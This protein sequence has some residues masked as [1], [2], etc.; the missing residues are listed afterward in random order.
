M[1]LSRVYTK[2]SKG[3]L[4]GSLKTRALGRSHA[5]LLALIDGKSTVSDLL[6]AAGTRLSENRLAAILDEL[7]SAGLIRLLTAT[8]P[9][10]DDLGF[11]STIIVSEANTQAFFDA[12]ADV[13]NEKLRRAEIQKAL[14]ESNAALLKEVTA[15]IAA[16][17]KA[18]D[19]QKAERRAPFIPEKDQQTRLAREAAAAQAAIKHAQAA[20]QA[21]TEAETRAKALEAEV[22]ARTEKAYQAEQE[23][24]KHAQSEAE[25][26]A[27]MLE[28][29][30]AR[31]QAEKKAQQ[32]VRA[33]EA[34]TLKARADAE[35]K[36]RLA[37]ATAALAQRE[38]QAKI[39]SEEEAQRSAEMKSRLQETEQAKIQALAEVQTLSQ[40]L[41]E[42][43]IAAELETRVKRRL[44]ARAREEADTHARLQAEAQ[45][46]L[47]AEA[48]LRAEAEAKARMEAEAKA[49]IAAEAA[50]KL[51]A[52]RK[53]RIE[54]EHKARLEA[55][56]RVKAETEA[57]K[58]A[59][60]KQAAAKAKAHAEEEARREAAAEAKRQA[61]AAIEAKRKAERKARATEEAQR[62]AA[63]AEKKQAEAKL[64]AERKARHEAEQKAA[65]AKR[66]A[67]A[68][69][70]IE[71]ERRAQIEEE[72]A[73]QEAEA[74]AKS[75]AEHKARQE[76]EQRA[77]E[78]KREAEAK[79]KIEA[80]RKAKIEEEKVRIEAEA[81]AKSEAEREKQR[82]AAAEAKHQAEVKAKIEAE[83]KAK[84]EEEKARQETEARAKSE[85]EQARREAEAAAQLKL[86][87]EQKAHE[88][89][90]QKA[91]AAADAAARAQA[92]A[93]AQQQAQ[94][95]ARRQAEEQ[96]RAIAAAEAA[97]RREAEAVK[98]QMELDQ[99]AEEARRA[100]ESAERALETERQARAVAESAAKNLVDER[101]KMESAA[102]SR[103]QERLRAAEMAS[104][105]AR[106]EMEEA[107]RRAQAEKKREEYEAARMR[108]EAEARAVAAARAAPLPVLAR[109]TRKPLVFDRRFY[110]RSALT[111]FALLGAAIGVAHVVPF[112]FYIPQVESALVQSLGQPVAI[113]ALH[114]SMYPM[115]HLALDAVV[116]GD[117]APTR[118]E[119]ANLYPAWRSLFDDVKVMRRVELAAV[120]F[121]QDSFDALPVWGRA[122]ARAVPLQFERVQIMDAKISHRLLDGFSFNAEMDARHGKFI[123][124]QIRSTDQ[125]ITIDIAPQGIAG[126]ANDDALRIELKAAGSLL[127]FEPRLPFDTIKISGLAQN[128]R[129]TMGSIDAQL[130]DGYLS[131]TAQVSW[132]DGWAV[133]ADLAL[134]QI[135]L[136]PGLAH[137]TQE[138]K[139]SGTLEAK[140]RLAAKADA[141]EDL[142]AAPQMQATFR[143]KNGEFSG[144]DLGRAIQ[145]P[146]QGGKTH[147]SDL[148][149][150][151]Q[152]T[153]G[154][155]QYR[156]IKLQGGVV[157]GFGTLEVN[158]A[159]NLSGR[160]IGELRTPSKKLRVPFSF[161]GSLAAPTL[162][163]ITLA[164]PRVVPTVPSEAPADGATETR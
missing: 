159:Q 45:A 49:R 118:I 152:T 139:L 14:D 6:N 23:A 88:E 162:K 63:L 164:P 131:G 34:A 24:R 51:E 36:A 17:A 130:F 87:A 13:E 124:A 98:R 4:D 27:R 57:Q 132:V 89:A 5:R 71:A 120:N 125:R 15:D 115:P 92:E 84:L 133:D 147:F 20:T 75:E 99:R 40:A 10:V 62:L 122:Q 103:E 108:A 16:E 72:K 76:A 97:V 26:K 64:E 128:G 129:L 11:S 140:V 143:V 123:Q 107:L 116:I 85:A 38:L 126:S 50:A 161:G 67:E 74:R 19:Q 18:L 83:R 80:E 154:R 141:L 119:K 145:T 52:E 29:Q 142:F 112:N 86:A 33:L 157:S 25:T 144:I 160:L 137:F 48:K 32:A 111:L 30:K 95:N 78:A 39:Q 102:K 114:F 93:L 54:A 138:S 82:F 31:T 163:A 134:Q 46:K 70:K 127:P 153:N 94:E 96:A 65:E 55:E 90:Q 77:A 28:A 91:Q 156:Q 148:S 136:E 43:R 61:E 12:Q 151:F 135:E 79:A 155:Y 59:A 69:A 2:T 104:T 158:A 53:A 21:R 113:Q 149:G 146:S 35:E 41:D 105:K 8:T 73:R 42:A 117:A 110:R 81:R 100:Q 44:E 68:K 47:E 101:A 106:G 56:A 9:E 150:Y 3:I 121:S 58:L 22:Q 37:K 1:D 66:E 7:V 60:E 109:R